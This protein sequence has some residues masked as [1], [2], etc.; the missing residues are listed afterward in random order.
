MIEEEDRTDPSE[1]GPW[2]WMAG[3]ALAGV[4]MLLMFALST[5]RY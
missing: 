4:I 1:Y 3:F 2:P 5:G